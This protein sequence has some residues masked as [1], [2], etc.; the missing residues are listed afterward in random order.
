MKRPSPA[1]AHRSVESWR[2]RMITLLA[3]AP[4]PKGK[5]LYGIKKRRAERALADAIASILDLWN[6]GNVPHP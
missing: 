5:I 2:K 3:D 4:Q 6:D 1:L